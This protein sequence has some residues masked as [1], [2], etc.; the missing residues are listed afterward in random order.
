MRA[1]TAIHSFHRFIHS[2]AWGMRAINSVFP[3]E[4]ALC[5]WTTLRRHGR[6]IN[7]PDAD[8]SEMDCLAKWSRTNREAGPPYLVKTAPRLS[9]GQ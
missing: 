4:P 9:R 6:A 7:S 1:A 2:G 8:P 3:D 5:L